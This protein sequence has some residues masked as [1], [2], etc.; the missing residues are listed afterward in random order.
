MSLY[1]PFRFEGVGKI[2]KESWALS[3]PLAI[4]MFY[5]FLIGLADVYV[6]GKFGKTAQAAYGF[7]F[8]LYFVFILIGIALSVGVVSVVSRRYTSDDKADFSA[9]VDSSITIVAVF[10]LIFGLAGIFFSKEIITLLRLPPEIKPLVVPFVRIY[11]LAFLFD[12]ILMTT[13]GIMRSCGMVRKSLCV[14]TIVSAINVPLNFILAFRTPLGLQGIAVATVIS[15]S[16]GA[17]ISLYG[18]KRFYGGFNYSSK[19]VKEILSISWPSGLL[20]AFW[21][22]GSIA[23]FMILGLLPSKNVEIMA[24]LTNGLR[25]ESAIFLPVFAFSMAN[26]VIVGNLLGKS[27]RDEAFR[28]GLITTWL[29]LAVTIAMTLIVM[30]NAAAIS[31]FLS[32]NNIVAS[33][34]MTYI[35]IALLSEPVMAWGVILGGGLNGAGDTIGVMMATALTVWCIRIPLSY[36]FG[37]YFGLGPVAV[38]WSMN[39]SVL[40]Q[41]ILIGRRYMMIRHGAK[42]HVLSP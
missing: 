12:Y 27:R 34:S 19:L 21:Q 1:K 11:S 10:G 37:V 2:L 23:L 40:V 24:A 13:N 3:W 38:W 32:D 31:R 16:A 4:I 33:E 14:M 26:A 25:I 8:Q 17:A 18:I 22:L 9:S 6:A 35:Y 36:I 20:Q 42:I 29:G 41:A 15:I 30:L 7:A 39:L 5:E 28:A